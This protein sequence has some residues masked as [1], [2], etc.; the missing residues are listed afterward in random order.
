MREK[1]DESAPSRDTFFLWNVP[2]S[3]SIS[4]SL[5]LLPLSLSLTMRTSLVAAAAAAAVAVA[6]AV[7]AARGV[8]VGAAP[9]RHV[10]YVLQE[11]EST[12]RADASAL[13]NVGLS[14]DAQSEAL[15]KAPEVAAAIDAQTPDAVDRLIQGILEGTGKGGVVTS[16]FNQ[17]GVHATII[18]NVNELKVTTLSTKKEELEKKTQEERRKVELREKTRKTEVAIEKVKNN[19]EKFKREH[20]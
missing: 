6:V 16:E 1:E 15:L 7:G 8:G 13:E 9:A 4:L 14:A 12:V 18:S 20:R 10:P 17:G 11:M 19:E 3:P 2:L 5:S